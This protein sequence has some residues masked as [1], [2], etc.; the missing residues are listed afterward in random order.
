MP[1]GNGDNSLTRRILALFGNGRADRQMLR[2]ILHGRSPRSPPSASSSDGRD[3]AQV[4]LTPIGR[5][6]S[7]GGALSTPFRPEDREYDVVDPL[8]LERQAF[9]EVCLLPHP[10]PP[11]ESQ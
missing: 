6:A 2:A 7:T 10:N 1:P 3:L 8:T 9:D 11:Q 4:V 5:S